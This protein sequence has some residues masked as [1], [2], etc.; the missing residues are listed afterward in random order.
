MAS[1]RILDRFAVFYNLNGTAPAAGGWLR[2][3]EA[4][5]TNPKAVYA[6]PELSTSN[7]DRIDL[8]GS[9]RMSLDAWGT[10]AYRVRQFDADGSQVVEMDDV[11]IPGGAGAALPPFEPGYLTNDS[12]QALWNEF[13]MLP[14]PTGQANKF[15]K[16]DGT[17]YVL[18]EINIPTPAAPDIVITGDRDNGSLRVGISSNPT[19]WLLQWGSAQSPNTGQRQSA[20]DV[21][22]PTS[23][24]SNAIWADAVIESAGL[25]STGLI[26]AK[27]TPVLAPD[28][29]RFHFDTQDFGNNA[30]RFNQVIPLRWIALGLVTVTP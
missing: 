1:F 19:K 15:P 8:D 26:A 7:G 22:F 20:V 23:F 28:K 3:Y 16:S 27:A 30:S 24:N 10:G 17:G 21:T 9:G 14:D 12:T 4:G 29:A 6:D 11:E 18:A 5:T 25:T 13:P 2:F